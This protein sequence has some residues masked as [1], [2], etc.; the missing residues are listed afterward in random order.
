MIQGTEQQD[1]I[2]QQPAKA[3]LRRYLPAT[4]ISI[5]VVVL[6]WALSQSLGE[7]ASLVLPRNQLQLA[8]VQRGD[9][10]RDIAVQ[11]RIV[12]A[13]A[14]T[15]YSQETGQVQLFKQPGEAVTLGDL[16]AT[17]TSPALQND[18]QQQQ[19]VLAGMQSEAERAVLAARE[20]QL[21]IEQVMNNA[22]VNLLAARRELQR[23]NQ[24]IEMGVIRQLDFDIAKDNLTKAELEF[25][26]AKRKVELAKDKLSFEQSSR[27]Q[28]IH[29]QQL[30][31]DE[32]QRK[33]AALNITAPVTGQL[34][35][36]LTEQQSHVLPGQALL[37]VIDLSQYE[38]EL[39]VPESYARDLAAGQQVEVSIG[40]QQLSGTVSTIAAEVR[41]NQVTARVRFAQADS[42]TLRQSQRLTARVILEHKTD[43]LKIA[44]GDF[45]SSGGGRQAYQV[46]DNQALRKN[47]ELG[48]LSV[49][50]V[51]ILNG[52]TEGEQW[53][54]S[55]LS[56]FKNESRVNL[57]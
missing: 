19:A 7:S 49:Q 17:I 56:D 9:L 6:A 2:M 8:T 30:V 20:Q 45:V 57:N 26:H 13:N 27:E 51:E 36:W 52:A 3:R 39:A 46:L 37:T 42:T 16:L 47:I 12:A 53:V 35:N 43:V 25:D 22:Q 1:K 33:V 11:G 41:N 10:V 23:A 14:P 38:A 48:A 18:L 28:D 31:V 34:G 29:R 40:N 5:T 21:D 4:V 32:L 44:R 55:N 54:I 50:W 15:L 24:S